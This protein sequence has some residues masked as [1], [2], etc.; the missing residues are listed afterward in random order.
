[1]R[2]GDRLEH[3]IPWGFALPAEAESGVRLRPPADESV[4]DRMDRIPASERTA[5]MDGAPTRPT[6]SI[7]SMPPSGVQFVMPP[8]S[9]M[10]SM[11]PPPVPSR[12]MSRA[13]PPPST[14]LAQPRGAPPDVAP[15]MH[16][17]ILPAVQALMVATACGW[18]VPPSGPAPT[19]LG[20]RLYVLFTTAMMAA[21]ATSVVF[22]TGHASAA[23]TAPVAAPVIT[24]N[25]PPA[26]SVNTPAPPAVTAI[27]VTPLAPPAPKAPARSG[28]PRVTSAPAPKPTPVSSA[29]PPATPPP[30][31]TAP[32][33][34]SA[35]AQ[36][37]AEMLREQLG[38]AVH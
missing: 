5:V 4:E 33:P 21:L 36:E 6:T 8:P 24:V 16:P 35:A 15:P 14:A 18:I 1:M 9:L 12:P 17:S 2:Q 19:A 38:A 32:A 25:V 20:W 34:A 30:P 7:P 26:P 27:A 29:A 11:P 3:T 37:T 13:P 28:A 31:P 10:S 22:L 23:V